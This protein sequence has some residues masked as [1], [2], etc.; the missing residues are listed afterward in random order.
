MGQ[1]ITHTHFTEADLARFQASL[2]RETSLAQQIFQEGGFAETEA[3]AGFELEAW[4][5]DR[6]LY[7]V[8]CNQSFLQRLADPLVV[9]ELSRFN[10]EVN[11]A[12]HVLQGQALRRL[13]QQLQNTWS[14]CVDTA[15]ADQA[16]A[17]AI[18]TLPTLRDRDLNLDTMTPSM[19]YTA[20][21]RQVFKARQG[22][23]IKLHIDQ[24]VNGQSLAS[25][26]D[27][28]MLEAA[29]TSFQVHLQV[30]ASKVARY[31]NASM[32]LS[33]P[34]LALSAN[35]PFLFGRALWHETRIPLFEQAVDCE[36]TPH[37]P[38]RRVSFG[39]GYLGSD[40]TDYF[41]DNAQRFTVLLPICSEAPDAAY[42]HLR[43]HNGT[44]WRWN[45]LLIGFDKAHAPHLRIEQRVMPAGPSIIDMIANAAFYWGAVH[46][47]AEQ[48]PHIGQLPPFEQVRANFYTA[49]RLGLDAPLHW[50]DGQHLRATD[51]LQRLLPAAREG[52]EQWG[53]DSEDI[54]HCMDVLQVRLRTG[55]NGA[56]WQLAHHARH[57]DLF[58]LTA[59]YLAHQRSGMAVHEWPV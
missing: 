27:D 44:V 7:P 38:E 45:R 52:L 30:P 25:S 12:P 9:A 56:A 32:L 21:N 2:N 10:F 59:D 55:Q 50:L 42:A 34:L 39:P 1:E 19:R 13:Q 5:V 23:P 41:T 33:A 24:G 58:R 49:A 29:T 57:G 26:H 48:L 16:T 18:G 43:L 37:S 6:N 40:P 54:G 47:L 51:L 14:R 46:T 4:L 20:L 28:V 3:T 35:S 11:G 31:L 53:L 36:R 8:P 15:H 22:R 17:I